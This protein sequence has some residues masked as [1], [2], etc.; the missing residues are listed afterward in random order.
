M[1][2]DAEAAD[3]SRSWERARAQRHQDCQPPDVSA[4]PAQD[5]PQDPGHGQART[6]AVGDREVRG[7]ISASAS[8]G[9]LRTP[10]QLNISASWLSIERTSLRSLPAADVTPTAPPRASSS[11]SPATATSSSP[12]TEASTSPR[13]TTTSSSTPVPSTTAG[14]TLYMSL[15]TVTS[16]STQVEAFQDLPMNDVED[17]GEASNAVAVQVAVPPDDASLAA[18]LYFP[19]SFGAQ[20]PVANET[21]SDDVTSA[22]VDALDAVSGQDV[23]PPGAVLSASP[24][25]FDPDD[26]TPAVVDVALPAAVVVPAGDTAADPATAVVV[27]TASDGDLAAAVLDTA[28]SGETVQDAVLDTAPSGET[29]QD[30]DAGLA[31]PARDIAADATP[32]VVVDTARDGDLPPAV[33]DTAPSGE[34]A[35]D[36]V[37]PQVNTQQ[38]DAVLP[39]PPTADVQAQAVD[40]GIRTVQAEPVAG[41]SNFRPVDRDDPDYVPS[42]PKRSRKVTSKR[43]RK[44]KSPYVESDE[45]P[46]SVDEEEQLPT[47]FSPRNKRGYRF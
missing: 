10:A 32:A 21:D 36:T 33:L 30:V 47:R 27:D 17:A 26:R 13:T 28:P 11:T 14:S 40:A 19:A 3:R 42:P 24:T 31:V 15:S 5:P 6:P 23:K 20:A 16:S 44:R 7:S 45:D 12:T 34:P 9:D 37:Q 25:L 1:A 35:Q 2:D 43:Y 41:S 38:S 8:L 22:G 39:L 4:S 18:H 29:V 46:S